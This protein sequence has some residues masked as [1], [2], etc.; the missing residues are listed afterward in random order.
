MALSLK[1]VIPATMAGASG[2]A[3]M[4]WAKN[5]GTLDDL[6]TK[7]ETTKKNSI[8]DKITESGK[9]LLQAGDSSKAWDIRKKQ[10]QDKFGKVTTNEAVTQWCNSSLDSEY[11]ESLYKNVSELCVVP[12]MSER[13]KFQNK[14]IIDLNNKDDTRWNKKV[15]DYP[16]NQGNKMPNSELKAADDSVTAEVIM[17]WC[18]GGVEEEFVDENERYNIV[19]TWCTA[20]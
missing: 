4:V 2:I 8:R 10:Y 7:P 18:K 15:T 5:S 13:L 17:N 11:Q 14:Q 12:T 6:L 1:K 9:K 3:G 19:S 16:K 20:S